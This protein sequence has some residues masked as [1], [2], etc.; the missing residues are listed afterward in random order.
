MGCFFPFQ[1]FVESITGIFGKFDTTK[2]FGKYR[3]SGNG[4]VFSQKF[5]DRTGKTARIFKFYTVGEY[6]DTRLHHTEIVG[7][8]EQINQGF[9][10]SV[11]LGTVL[12]S[13]T[14]IIHFK[15]HIHL[16]F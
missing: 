15:R 1:H 14:Q 3:I 12:N 16:S 4:Y 11:K 9:P 2:Q 6:P 10:D 7:M 13:N 8:H 5:F